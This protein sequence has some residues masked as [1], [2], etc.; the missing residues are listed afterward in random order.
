MIARIGIQF[1]QYELLI[2]SSR[3]LVS[4][5][6]RTCQSPSSSVTHHASPSPT[7]DPKMVDRDPV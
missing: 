2:T 7:C 1:I 6:N 5:T 3:C 4:S